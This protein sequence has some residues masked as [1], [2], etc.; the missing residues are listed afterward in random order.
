MEKFTLA[1][2]QTKPRL[3]DL[4]W[5]L[6]NH[7]EIAEKA[8]EKGANLILF[9]EL[10]LTGYSVRDLNSE[11]ALKADD[12]FFDP[13]KSLSKRIS[14]ASG[15]VIRDEAGGIRNSLVYFED[16]VVKHVHYKVYLP[17]YGIFEEQRYFLP[18]KR[19][20]AIDTK[21]G[22][23][24]LLICEDLWHVSLPYLLAIQGARLILASAASPTRLSGDSSEHPGHL[25]NSE[26]HR[27]FARLLSLY[28]AFAGRV[29]FEDGVNFW[30]GS[31]VVSPHGEVTASAKLFDE[32][33]IY[34]QIDL[35]EVDRARLFARHFLDEN[36]ELVAAHLK[37]LGY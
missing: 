17:T 11:V 21:F 22:R 15:A 25:V 6:N 27:S 35:A 33:I 14:V 4:K 34:S 29:G 36:P 8:L 7:L 16:G 5:N 32:E 23:L 1:V 18:G 2:G 28:I 12:K 9:P 13:L 24:G 19:V 3:G 31:E 26:Q 37:A 30:G 20:Q 10:S